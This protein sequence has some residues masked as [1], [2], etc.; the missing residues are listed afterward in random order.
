MDGAEGLTAEQIE[1][2]K[3]LKHEFEFYA[4]R[5]LK[6]KVKDPLAIPPVQSFILNRA[7][8]HVHALLE[9]QLRETGK[10]RALLLKGRQ[11]GMSTYVQGRFYHKV[12]LNRGRQAFILTHEQDATDTL[13]AM[14]ERYHQNVPPNFR[15]ALGKSNAKEMN[16]EGRDA[17][18]AV[19]TAGGKAVGRS[20]MAHIFHGSEVAFWPNA[21]KHMAG[22]FQIVPNMAGTEIILESTANGYDEVFFP[23]WQRAEAGDSEYLAIFTPWFWDDDYRLKVPEGYEF[24]AEDRD[25][26]RLHS[27]DDDQLFWRRVKIDDELLGDETLFQQEY[28]A[29]S[30]EAFVAFTDSYIKSADVLRA[31]KASGLEAVGAKIV[32]VDPARF[33]DD[34]TGWVERIGRVVNEATRY[35]NLSTMQLANLIM[36][37][38]D[39][40]AIDCV[41]IDTV[42]L[43]VGVYDRCVEA[44]Y[45]HIVREVISG[46]RSV[47]PEKFTNKKAEIWHDMKEWF[48]RGAQIPDRDD[49]Q[50]DLLCPKYDYEGKSRLRIESKDSIRARGLRS[51]DLSDALAFTFAEP[52]HPTIKDDDVDRERRKDRSRRPDWRVN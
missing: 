21:K 18:Y 46:E 13:F 27:L 44:G 4:P 51:P 47:F 16:F 42:G 28:P 24:S 33:G 5:M 52:V 14:T 32:G 37:R 7:Q 40:E 22:V 20:K 23:A 38:V 6:V 35:R 49:L 41:F 19:A 26:Q 39:A 30:A 11:M 1:K 12:S 34:A 50:T 3:R 2:L 45:G 8:Q 25:Y 17:G 9:R 15:F 29:T 48:E 31:R 10:V 36:R 43:G